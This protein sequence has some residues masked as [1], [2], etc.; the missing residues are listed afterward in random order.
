MKHTREQ[1]LRGTLGSSARS[2]AGT[3]IVESAIVLPCLFLI[4]FGIVWVAL[5][6]NTAS[7]LHRAARQAVAIAA[8]SSCAQCGNTAA[9]S[10]QVVNAL[11]AVLQA[12]HLNSANLTAYSPPLACQM[13]PQPA[14]STVQNVEICRGVPLTCGRDLAGA[15]VACQTPPVACGAN[16]QVGVR[17]SFAYRYNLSLPLAGLRGITIPASAQNPAED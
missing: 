4:I 14:C 1:V 3:E 16:A 5:A 15:T 11:V 8:T 2:Q 9:N 13:T 17:V 10:V 6:Y 7:T 12:D